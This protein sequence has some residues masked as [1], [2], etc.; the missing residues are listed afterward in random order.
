MSFR[1]VPPVIPSA[2]YVIPAK[3]GIQSRREG[4]ARPL[5]FSARGREPAQRD[6]SA[7]RRSE[8]QEVHTLTSIPIHSHVIPLRSHVI[9]SVA[10]NLPPSRS[11]RGLGGCTASERR[12]FQSSPSHVIP[13]L[14]HVIPSAARNLPPSR[15]V[16]GLGGCIATKPTHQHQTTNTPSFPSLKIMAI[17]VHP[18]T[19]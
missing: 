14:S 11:V 8:A 10:R 17:M 2:P 12:S 13:M 3:T 19:K 15:S 9:P 7:C 18:S 6:R 4:E 1:S 5:R 16:R